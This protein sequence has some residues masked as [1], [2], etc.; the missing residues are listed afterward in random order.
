M[1]KEKAWLLLDSG[2]GGLSYAKSLREAFPYINFIYIADNLNFPYGEKSHEALAFLI[3]GLVSSVEL[4]FKV[5]GLIFVC[6]TASVNLLEEMKVSKDYPV[7]GVYP[8]LGFSQ[9]F[10]PNENILLLATSSTVHSELVENFLSLF[11]DKIKAVPVPSLVRFAESE[12]E[13]WE[14]KARE[15]LKILKESLKEEDWSIQ[16]IYLGC[17][18]FIHLK[19]WLENIFPDSHFLDSREFLIESL[20]FLKEFYTLKKGFSYFYLTTNSENEPYYREKALE[21]GFTYEG[22]L[23]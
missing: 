5:E 17:T 13:D 6:N 22:V 18:H 9:D 8:F 1:V 19:D 12:Q 16:N 3:K 23:I 11:P 10:S 14:K 2:I 4:I 7:K 21:A 15:E 20:S